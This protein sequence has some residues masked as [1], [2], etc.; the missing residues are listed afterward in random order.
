MAEKYVRIGSMENVHVFDDGDFDAGLETDSTIKVGVAPAANEDVVRLVDV[1][2]VSAD[3]VTAT[4]N[5]TDHSIARGHGGAKV[6]QDSLVTIDDAGSISLPALQTVDGI[7]ISV[8]AADVDAHHNE[9]HNAAS[10][11]DIASTGAEID[12]AVVALLGDGTAGRVLRRL[13]LLV[14]DGTNANTIKCT[15]SS[16]WNGDADGPTDNCALGATTGNFTLNAGGTNLIIEAAALSG[17]VIMAIGSVGFNATGLAISVRVTAA[18]NDISIWVS[19]TTG[20][21]DM[22]VL[23]DT[24]AFGL[25]ILYLTDA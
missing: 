25:Q 5:I 13:Y 10:H 21:T 17:N 3:I 1:G 12:A 22:A 14:E 15:I 20:W 6:L 4:A 18:T 24:G 11:S 8:H 19:K 16:E 23:T 2:G 9:S 7:D